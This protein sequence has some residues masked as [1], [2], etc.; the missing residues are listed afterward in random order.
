MNNAPYAHKPNNTFNF[1][2]RFYVLELR[3]L[4]KHLISNFNAM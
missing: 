2:N 3:D 1:V 4:D